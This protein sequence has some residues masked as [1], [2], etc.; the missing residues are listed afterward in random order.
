MG[1]GG[2]RND[3]GRLVLALQKDRD[4]MAF[5]QLMHRYQR[6]LFGFIRRQIG[7]KSRAEDLFHETF[8]RIYSRIDTCAQPDA[9]RPWA[10]GIAA[11]I[12]KNEGRRRAVRAGERPSDAMDAH[13]ATGPDPERAAMSSE[14]GRKIQSALE[15]LPPPQREVFILYH[16]SRLSYEEIATALELPLGTVK[17]RMNS[18]LTELR[19][20][21]VAL[22]ED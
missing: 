18:A 15:Q 3:D 13:P 5:E 2:E 1:K 14:L 16:Y 10:F 6:P 4:P 19:T 17:S 12:C 11:N 20:L 9:F 7:D 21:L 8:L 22:R